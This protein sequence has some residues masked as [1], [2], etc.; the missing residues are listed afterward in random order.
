MKILFDKLLVIKMAVMHE[1]MP[2]AH[3]MKATTH[4]KPRYS[5][6]DALESTLDTFHL[7]RSPTIETRDKQTETN[8]IE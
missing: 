3:K 2:V 8:L 5:L 1:T 6:Q 4:T 7:H